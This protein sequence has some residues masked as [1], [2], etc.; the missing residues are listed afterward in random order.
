MK[1]RAASGLNWTAIHGITTPLPY[2]YFSFIVAAD[3]PHLSLFSLT[4]GVFVGSVL[5]IAGYTLAG[6]SIGCAVINHAIGIPFDQYRTLTVVSCL[7]LML[8]SR[9]QFSLQERSQ[10]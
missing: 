10:A 8:L 7:I 4:A 1:D 3:V 9:L 6:A 5:Y 2:S